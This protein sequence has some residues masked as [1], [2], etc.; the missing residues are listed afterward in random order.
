MPDILTLTM[1][2]A[3]DVATA[4]HK[5]MDTHKLR[6]TTEVRHPGGGGINVAR[7]LH[8]LG[9]DCEAVYPL[10][11]VRGEALRQLMDTEGVRSRCL[12]IAGE[13]RENFTVE[14]VSSGREFRFV[15]P[16]PQ[17]QAQEWQACLEAA[18]ATPGGYLVAS[19]SLPPGVPDGF[20]AQLAKRAKQQGLRVVLDASGAALAAGLHE[21]VYLVKPSLRE[22]RDLT[23][24]PLTEEAQWR[25]AARQLI[26][27]GQAEV[28][29]LSMGPQGA[30]L[31]TRDGCWRAPGLAVQV[32]SATGAGDSFVG[33]MLWALNRGA[34]LPEAFRFGVAAGSAALMSVGTGLCQP[35]DMERLYESTVLA[36]Y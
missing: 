21:G 17:L 26:T 24:L 16:G 20:Y 27:H 11:G 15:L 12:P 13:T 32:R 28:V 4:T 10:G 22:L 18:L 34:G 19:G 35:A 6:C 29:A 2:P 7:V 14:E 1:N 31:V 8:R 3:L 5:V 30:M 36:Q 23:G 9:V 33:A 25:D